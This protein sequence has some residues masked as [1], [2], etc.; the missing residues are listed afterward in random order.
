MAVKG[1][2]GARAWAGAD[3]D[4]EAEIFER[5]VEHLLDVG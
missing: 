5:G 3:E 1:L 2:M 4:V